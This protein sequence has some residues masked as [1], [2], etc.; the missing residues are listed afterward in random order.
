MDDRAQAQLRVLREISVRFA[1]MRVRWWLR[2]GWAI[3]V[4]LGRVT[5]T[6]A[7]IDMIVWARHRRRAHQALQEAGLALARQFP[8]Q[9]DFVLGEAQV[10][11]IYLARRSD[12]VIITRGFLE[13]EW[14]AGSL[15]RRPRR[16]EGIAARVTGPR[17]LLWEKETYKRG[18]GRPLRPKDHVSMQT[19]REMIAAG[20][21]AG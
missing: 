7:D 15:G 12:G 4:L 5:R 1:E 16:L 6:H 3:D 14:P 11:V 19:L 2:G 9:T 17:Q 18:T 10:S 13:W 21:G 20:I 8:N